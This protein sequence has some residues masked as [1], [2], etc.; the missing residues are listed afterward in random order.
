MTYFNRCKQS[1]PY[2]KVNNILASAAGVCCAENFFEHGM[3]DLGN[4]FYMMPVCWKFKM[5]CFFGGNRISKIGE[6]FLNGMLLN[7]ELA[8]YIVKG[9]SGKYHVNNK[10]VISLHWFLLLT[11]SVGLRL[12][13]TQKNGMLTKKSNILKEILN[14]KKDNFALLHVKTSSCIEEYLEES[15]I[16]KIL[17]KSKIKEFEDDTRRLRQKKYIKYIIRSINLNYDYFNDDTQKALLN[18]CDY[19]KQALLNKFECYKQ[20]Y[21]DQLTAEQELQKLEQELP[22]KLFF[23]N[24]IALVS[25]IFFHAFLNAC[26]YCYTQ[27]QKI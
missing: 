18:T 6:P 11:S 3:P 26:Y 14:L 22:R 16:R 15:S 4:L 12:Y 10:A 25:G 8:E 21:K 20:R 2:V 23:G 5:G 13:L 27:Y 19:K 7:F 17:E 1:N 9:W 24:I